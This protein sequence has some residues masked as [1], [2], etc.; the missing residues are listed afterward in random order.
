MY[1]AQIYYNIIQLYCQYVETIIIVT[2]PSVR[3]N[4][5]SPD[6]EIESTLDNPRFHAILDKLQSLTNKGLHQPNSVSS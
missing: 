6:V 3:K 2:V 1:F 4:F 5:I